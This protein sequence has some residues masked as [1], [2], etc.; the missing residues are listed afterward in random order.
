MKPELA[1]EEYAGVPV[2]SN[3]Q[4]I[5]YGYLNNN[6]IAALSDGLMIFYYND[7][8]GVSTGFLGLVH[9]AVA[10]ASAYV[11]GNKY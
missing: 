11:S 9:L 2:L 5:L 6:N 7:E 1:V 10:F 3:I 8:L 4:L